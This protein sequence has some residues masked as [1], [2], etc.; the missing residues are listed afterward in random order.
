MLQNLIHEG[1]VIDSAHL[2]LKITF[3]RYQNSELKKL[4]NMV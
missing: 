4:L 2:G 1:K 3:H